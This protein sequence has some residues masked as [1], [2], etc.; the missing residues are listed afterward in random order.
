MRHLQEIFEIIRV[1]EVCAYE[2][3]FTYLDTN[4]IALS[5]IFHGCIGAR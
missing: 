1:S 2:A 4:E 5:R 3:R